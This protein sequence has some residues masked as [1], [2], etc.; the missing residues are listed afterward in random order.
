MR[1]IRTQSP[2]ARDISTLN[3]GGRRDDIAPLI[4]HLG[5]LAEKLYRES[6][7]ASRS[8]GVVISPLYHVR[9]ALKMAK[10]NGRDLD[11][12]ECVEL[13]N[14][15]KRYQKDFRE[16]YK[17]LTSQLNVLQKKMRSFNR[18]YGDTV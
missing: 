1:V 3:E 11:V 10:H 4:E 7:N 12:K 18:E 6:E 14:K 5:L 13:V 2:P 9:E 15:T 17:E 16:D 8:L